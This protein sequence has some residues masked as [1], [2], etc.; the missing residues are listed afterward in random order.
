[1]PGMLSL[2]EGSVG[3]EGGGIGPAIMLE[4]EGSCDG[5]LDA[6]PETI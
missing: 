6:P 5:V 4:G 1:M 2:T 3:V